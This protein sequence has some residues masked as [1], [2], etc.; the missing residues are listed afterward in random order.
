MKLL[1][2]PLGLLLW[3]ISTTGYGAVTFYIDLATFNGVTSTTIVEDFES[4]VPKDTALVSFSS[5]GI[6]YTGID[7]TPANPNVWVASSGYT[8]FGVPV[9]T[10]SV[11]TATGDE[12]FKLDF[13]MPVTELGFDTYL[14]GLGPTLVSVFGA[15]GLLDT[16]NL[17]QDPTTI[18]F[19][20]ITSTEN[21]TS[22]RWTTTN[23]RTVNTGIDNI[24][25]NA[26]PIPAAAFMFAPALLGFMGL[27][28][29]AKN[30]IA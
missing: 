29:R 28:R 30:T 19:L 5:N 13:S 9:T 10:S 3:A 8:N 24:R 23:G 26:V 21:I 15:G 22:L 2:L 20:G 25:I 14:N 11:L 1:T 4:V 12:D 6:T 17:F 18:G 7:S 27:R 16:I